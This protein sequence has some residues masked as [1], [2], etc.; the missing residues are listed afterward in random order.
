[1]SRIGTFGASQMYLSRLMA[2]QQRLNAT[3]LQVAT[4]KKSPN[5]TGLSTD[6][7][8]LLNFETETALAT[9]FKKNNDFAATKL[10]AAQTSLNAVQT[11]I[12][13]FRDRL[14]SFMQ[15]DTTNPDKIKELQGFAVQAMTQMSSYLNVNVDGQYLFSGGRV[16]TSPVKL[17]AST[18]EDFQAIYDGFTSTYP[19][20]R[21]ANLQDIKLSSADMGLV[22]FDANYGA[23]IP[24]NAGAFANVATSSR[25][26]IG[27]T[28][29]NN[30][31]FTI[32]GHV[33]TNVN[34]KP[35]AETANAGNNTFISAPTGTLTHGAT[36]DLAFAFNPAGDMTITPA[37]ANTLA[38]LTP[39]TQI[40][41][42]GSDDLDGDGFGDYDGTFKVTANADGKVTLATN[43]GA[44]LPET[45]NVSGL[46]LSQDTG[47]DGIPDT[48]AGLGAITGDAKFTISGNTVTLTVPPAVLRSIPCSQ[49]ATPSALAAP[50]AMTAPSR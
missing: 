17:P 16:G 13:Q 24:T 4:E 38:D 33:T 8:R 39:G 31:D 9:Q 26:T 41:I 12:K 28:N 49:R 46:S 29:A 47:A 18:L 5:Y 36:G 25:V 35:L 10:T 19:T 7:T 43:T 50:R 14:D 48:L 30:D 42:S 6:A 23:I 45:V 15:G 37:N 2:T 1:M 22:T 34:G 11:T 32:T 44:A 20:T 27:G 40:T 3:S 21:A